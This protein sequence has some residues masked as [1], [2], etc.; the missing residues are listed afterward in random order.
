MFWA[1]GHTPPN[2]VESSHEPWH[3][4]AA[5]PLKSHNNHVEQWKAA[6]IVLLMN[7]PLHASKSK[8]PSVSESNDMKNKHISVMH[9][10]EY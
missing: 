7:L 3:S 6:T 2:A 4:T 5:H 1:N 10:L 8:V 9:Y